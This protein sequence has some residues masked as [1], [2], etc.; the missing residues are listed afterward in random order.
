MNIEELKQR[1][2]GG[3]AE[4]QFELG[5]LYYKGNETLRRNYKLAFEWCLV[6]AEQG[7]VPA[8]SLVAEM[9][10]CGKKIGKELKKALFWAEKAAEQND[11]K[12]LRVL[13]DL[14]YSGPYSDMDKYK[15]CMEK[16]CCLGDDASKYNLGIYHLWHEN[17]EKG[18]TLLE[19]LAIQD[20]EDAVY[21]LG[22]YYLKNKDYDKAEEWLAKVNWSCGECFEIGREYFYQENFDKADAW[23][24]R[25]V[26]IDKDHIGFIVALYE[27]GCSI[28]AL[29]PER[30]FYWMKKAAEHGEKYAKKKVLEV[31][32][33]I[34]KEKK[35]MNV[36]IRCGA[37]NIKLE[38][39]RSQLQTGDALHFSSY[40]ELAGYCYPFNKN[41]AKG[42]TDEHKYWLLYYIA[43]FFHQ[44]VLMYANCLGY[45][46]FL[47]DVELHIVNDGY[48]GL[49]GTY[50]EKRIIALNPILICYNPCILSDTIIHELT[51]FVEYNHKRVFYDLL[52]QNV[53]KCGLQ[54]ELHGRENNS[55]GKFPTSINIWKNEIDNEGYKQIRALLR[56]KQTRRHYNRKSPKQ[57]SFKFKE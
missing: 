33:R 6:A 9:Y 32:R 7:Y 37:L 1:A 43:D 25:A 29:L 18:K 17:V 10:C 56:I 14:Y 47:K 52:E 54:K 31:E 40:E 30:L 12:G 28:K 34:E 42:I 3:D 51:H 16:A 50:K 21:Q 24:E 45:A 23:F 15:E 55:V 26:A 49:N 41:L 8:Q 13:A 5:C 20:N 38:E 27:Y 4:A 36:I 22:L 53:I 46:H 57:L 44:Q 35:R 39:L 48:C 19:E 2:A 11:I